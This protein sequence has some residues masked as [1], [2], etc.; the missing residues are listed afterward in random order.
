MCK[1]FYRPK[2]QNG[3]CRTRQTKEQNPSLVDSRALYIYTSKTLYL[4][5]ID[6]DTPHG[7]WQHSGSLEELA[8]SSSELVINL[9]GTNALVTMGGEERLP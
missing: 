3:F 7:V 4:A 2:R 6:F 8:L 9:L 1:N 5:G